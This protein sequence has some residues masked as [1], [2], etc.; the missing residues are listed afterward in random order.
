MHKDQNSDLHTVAEATQDL[1]VD[2]WKLRLD[3]VHPEICV[4]C[5]GARRWGI[6][7]GRFYFCDGHNTWRTYVSLRIKR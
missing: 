5:G 3:S 4:V 6:G 7:K 2:T 1:R